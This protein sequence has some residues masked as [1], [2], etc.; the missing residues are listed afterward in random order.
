M[1]CIWIVRGPIIASVNRAD[2]AW[3][4]PLKTYYYWH[5]ASYYR[6][7]SMNRAWNLRNHCKI[8]IQNHTTSCATNLLCICSGMSVLVAFHCKLERPNRGCDLDVIEKWCFPIMH[9]QFQ[10]DQ[11]GRACVCRMFLHGS[12]MFPQISVCFSIFA[13]MFLIVLFECW[14]LVHVSKLTAVHVLKQGK[15]SHYSRQQSKMSRS[16]SDLNQR[17][18]SWEIIALLKSRTSWSSWFSTSTKWIGDSG[19][20]QGVSQNL[21][22]FTC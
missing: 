20:Q 8:Y 1:H 12:P 11:R 5:K 21:A 22:P 18:M 10:V 9:Q 7:P 16:T 13:D 14:L 15:T 4:D 19:P 6:E 17:K 3:T 2:R